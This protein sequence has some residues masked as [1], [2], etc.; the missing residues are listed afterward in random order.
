MNVSVI[1][2]TYNRGHV[3]GDAIASVLAQSFSDLEVLVVDDGSS[4]DTEQRVQAVR[5]D[6][7]RYIRVPH[8]GVSAARNTGVGLSRGPLLSFLDSDDVWKPE[9]LAREVA[10]LSRHPT[11]DG[12]FDDADKYH[13]DIYV[14]SFIRQT[15]VF[16]RRFTWATDP[17]GV[18]LP[19][20]D[21]VLC[22]LE[23]VPI[24]TIAFTLRRQAFQ[25]TGGFNEAWTSFEDWEFFLRFARGHRVGY[26]PASLATIRMSADSL[27]LIDAKQGRSAMAQLLAEE[28]RRLKGD[29]EAV[30][31][32]TRGLARLSRR[33]A[34]YHEEAGHR[35]LA[36]LACLRGYRQTGDLGLVL[37]AAF[38]AMPY[39]L[40]RL[41]RSARGRT[42]PRS[43]TA[44]V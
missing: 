42:A 32:A 27:H 6:R 40:Q 11:S 19:Q 29:P 5:D 31:A 4:D 25:Q 38:N 24:V 3:I 8:A 2:P 39:P 14:P 23:E 35:G 30:A 34:W 1:I 36:V 41:V 22:L 43:I 9:K 21:L 33:L 13:G 26:I 28:R 37:C 16:S 10:F 18:V 15:Q 44:S 20:R 12:V 17:E 7:V